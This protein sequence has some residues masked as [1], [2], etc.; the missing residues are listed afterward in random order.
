MRRE[1]SRV[2]FLMCPFCVR[3]VLSNETTEIETTS[4][5]ELDVVDHAVPDVVDRDDSD[6]VGRA[7]PS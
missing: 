2:S 3:G 5:D 1:T 7:P 4:T 6:L